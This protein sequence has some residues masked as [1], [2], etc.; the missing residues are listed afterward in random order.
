[1]FDDDDDRGVLAQ[2][3]PRA[4]A[5]LLGV[6]LLGAGWMMA[7]NFL[8]RVL[9]S[10]V[11]LTRYAS[12]SAWPKHRGY[13]EVWKVR[14]QPDGTYAAQ[15]EFLYEVD[16]QVYRAWSARFDPISSRTLAGAQEALQAFPVGKE[17]NVS[18]NPL[19]PTDAVLDIRGKAWGSLMLRVAGGCLIVGVVAGALI[20]MEVRTLAVALAVCVLIGFGALCRTFHTEAMA[21]RQNFSTAKLWLRHSA[22]EQMRQQWSGLKQGDLIDAQKAI[23]KPDNISK[24][25]GGLQTW[26]YDLRNGLE[27]SGSVDLFPSPQ[28]LRVEKVELPYSTPQP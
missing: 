23:G 18:V 9:G 27:T 25:P 12:A 1:M 10:F 17:V 4:G 14:H 26:H 5:L 7:G 8:G 20:L 3:L 13:V 15:A 19:D 21:Q 2:A 24:K 16:D 6:V 28:G 22:V 11:D